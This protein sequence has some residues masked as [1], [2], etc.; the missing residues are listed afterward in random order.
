MQFSRNCNRIC[1]HRSTT[2]PLASHTQINGGTE[3]KEEINVRGGGGVCR[4][5]VNGQIRWSVEGL[6]TVGIV[7]K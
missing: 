7:V 6:M 3:D 2:V 1:T 4:E 5:E